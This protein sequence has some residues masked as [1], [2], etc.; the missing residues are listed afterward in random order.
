MARHE[1]LDLMASV[2][3]DVFSPRLLEKFRDV[4]LGETA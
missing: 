3:K 1:A 2:G 4:V